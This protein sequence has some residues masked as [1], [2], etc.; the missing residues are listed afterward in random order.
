MLNVTMKTKVN[1]SPQQVWD[2][3]KDFN[4][5]PKFIAA[6]AD[7]TMQ[8]SGVGAVRTLTLQEG[9]PPIVERLESFDEQARTL[10]YSIIKSPLP[11]TQYLATMEVHD[12]GG[13]QCELVWSS[14]FQAVGASDDE[15]KKVVEGVYTGGFE[16]LRKIYGD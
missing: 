7:S 11:L 4:G 2:T 12:L 10:S 8:G 9:G 3:I 14:T 5:L 1:A 15:A 13:S 16:G 6:I